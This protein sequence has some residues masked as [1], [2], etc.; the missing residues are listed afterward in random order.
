MK[1]QGW[2]ALVVGLS[3]A[4]EVWVCVVYNHSL[5]S[6]FTMLLVYSSFFIK[7]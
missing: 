3:I 6:S 5:L 1:V 2:N 7:Q 4:N